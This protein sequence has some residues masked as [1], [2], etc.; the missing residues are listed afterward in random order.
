MS[1]L[2]KEK[3]T[4]FQTDTV[5]VDPL[6]SNSLCSVSNQRGPWVGEGTQASQASQLL[7]LS[8]T[9]DSFFEYMR[10]W[11]SKKKTA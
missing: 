6:T 10:S 9:P 5:L 7:L 1:Q 3:E 11:F 2:S 4:F 8:S